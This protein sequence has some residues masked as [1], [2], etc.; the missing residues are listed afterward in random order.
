M[1]STQQ[2]DMYLKAEKVLLWTATFSL[3]VSILIEGCLMLATRRN[4]QLVDNTLSE[5]F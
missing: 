2:Y 3:G 1:E 5:G 4:S